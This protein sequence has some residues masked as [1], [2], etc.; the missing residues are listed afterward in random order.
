MTDA[1]DFCLTDPRQ[2]Q[3]DKLRILTEAEDEPQFAATLERA[4]ARVDD[5]EDGKLI[6]E[7]LG[8]IQHLDNTLDS[9]FW[10]M[11]DNGEL[12]EGA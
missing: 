12:P 4:K 5:S 10:S 7:L 11:S 8:I 3:I 9:Y 2:M 6:G 1:H